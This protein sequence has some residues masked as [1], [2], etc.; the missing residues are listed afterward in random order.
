[1]PKKPKTIR[2]LVKIA[3]RWFSQYVRLKAATGTGFCTCCTCGTI[4]FWKK[5]DAGHWINRDKYGTRYELNNCH[6]QCVSCNRFKSGRGAEYSDFIIN[7]YGRDEFDWLIKLSRTQNTLTK[8]DLKNI[9]ELC[10]K[11]VKLL[12]KEKGL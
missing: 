9:I 12:R 11:G 3:D 4:K 1:M 5:I 8:D 7:N 2:Q 6:P 10:K